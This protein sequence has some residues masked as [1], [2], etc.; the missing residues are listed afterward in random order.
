MDKVS[1][2]LSRFGLKSSNTT[3]YTT[4]FTHRSFLNEAKQRLSSNE[5]LEFLGDAVLQLIVSSYLY[6]ERPKDAEG[7]LTNLRAYIVKTESLAQVAK[8]L[9][10]GSL[11]RLSR[12]EELSSG[13]T[14]PQILANTYEAFLGAVYSDLGF[15][16][17]QRFVH[18][19]LLPL[20]KKQVLTGAPRDFKSQL[21]EISQSK[22]QLS[23]KY[24]II[25]TA[26]PDHAKKFTVGVFLNGKQIGQ[27]TGLNKQQ[28]EEQAAEA[29]L[30]TLS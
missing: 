20:F 1:E 18:Q 24:K 8:D 11:L 17:A 7:E 25:S 22:S 14:N 6:L 19:T 10:L 5:R 26:G 13:R 2:L 27:G 29:A 23:P 28:A 9:D 30:K 3:L 12:G 4:A 15:E 16:L 21:Q